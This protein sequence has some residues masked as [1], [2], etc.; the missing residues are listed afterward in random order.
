MKKFKVIFKSNATKEE[1]GEFV[2]F[3]TDDETIKNSVLRLANLLWY[4]GADKMPKISKRKIDFVHIVAVNKKSYFGS[5]HCR[6]NLFSP[7]CF[8]IYC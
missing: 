3:A 7:Y 5:A 1:R 4:G 8:E 2:F 6:D